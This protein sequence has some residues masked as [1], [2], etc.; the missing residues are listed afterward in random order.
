MFRIITST[1]SKAKNA[2]PKAKEDIIQILAK[3]FG[4]NL[5]IN[6]IY[7]NDSAN[8]FK[9]TGFIFKKI[10]TILRN[11]FNKDT[12]V[13]QYPMSSKFELL[14]LFPKK[15]T[16]VV[17]HDIHGLRFLDDKKN[18]KEMKQLKKFS[19][20]IAHNDKMKEYLIDNG[21]KKENI[22]KIE[23]FDY[24]V[25]DKKVENKTI[26]G[27]AFVGNLAKEKT[28]FIHQLDENKMKFNLHL[29]GVGIDKDINS[30]IVYEGSFNP[31]ELPLYI[32]QKLGLVWD[33]NYDESDEDKSYKNYTKYNNPH[34]LSCYVT[35]GIPVIVWEK[36]AVA[37][38]VKENNIGYV[39]NNIYDINNLS[40]D[41]YETKKKNVIEISKKVRNG[42][43]TNKVFDEILK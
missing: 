16:I 2:G 36:A 34:K 40:L 21:I 19:H 38:F 1:N 43:Y 6:T 8:K 4:E 42:Y 29:Y 3:R 17:I 25:S 7:E 31:D 15:R 26:D 41:D 35:S 32:N 9:K 28:P 39:I 11:H 24:L 14:S 10:V 37:N 20:I 33:G 13:I 30:K 23:L 5:I 12:I 18:K 22:Y 27:I